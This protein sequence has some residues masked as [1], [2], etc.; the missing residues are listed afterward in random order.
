MYRTANFQQSKQNKETKF[1]KNLLCI[2][3]KSYVV[4]VTLCLALVF[5]SG[6][7]A[8]AALVM[9]L[10]DTSTPGADVT[11]TDADNDG[12]V[13][14]TGSIGS[15]SSVVMTGISKPIL[16]APNSAKIQLGGVAYVRQRGHIGN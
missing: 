3:N 14:F 9:T 6:A 8:Q 12:L 15:F 11:V 13:N 5:F 16:S 10:D 1:M 7:Q 4:L 2:A